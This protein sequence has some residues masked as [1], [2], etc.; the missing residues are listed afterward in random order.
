MLAVIVLI[1]AARARLLKTGA[2]RVARE[3]P[4]QETTIL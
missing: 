2:I 1:A 3:R 4:A